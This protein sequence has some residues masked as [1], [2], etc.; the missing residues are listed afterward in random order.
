MWV[1]HP[2][3]SRPKPL[4][5][6]PVWLPTP[7]SN[8]RDQRA[9]PAYVAGEWQA[10]IWLPLLPLRLAVSIRVPPLGE[11]LLPP[12]LFRLP[13]LQP[14]TTAAMSAFQ[15]HPL[16]GKPYHAMHD[17]IW[18]S[19]TW[20]SGKLYP[21]INSTQTSGTDCYQHTQQPHP[22]RLP[23]C[24][25]SL[26]DNNGSQALR[27]LREPTVSQEAARVCPDSPFPAPIRSCSL[28]CR[29]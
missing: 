12:L 10:I 23:A 17:E 20:P 24:K 6:N 3:C 16:P 11:C 13:I 27:W 8:V 4:T 29:A 1:R 28:L 21:C 22:A 14:H 9:S 26:H 7:N 19:I 25:C 15:H 2:T 18:H 5:L